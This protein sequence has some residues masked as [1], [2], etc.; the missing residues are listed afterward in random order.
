MTQHCPAC[1]RPNREGARFC[2]GCGVQLSATPAEPSA[3]GLVSHDGAFVGRDAELARLARCLASATGGR[4]QVAVVAGEP[5]IGKTR[6][7]QRCAAEAAARGMHVFWGRCKEEPGAPPYWPWLQALET[8]ASEADDD[9]L[10]SAL[11]RGAGHV[12][13]LAESIGTRFADLP[14]VVRASDPDRARFQTFDAFTSFWKRVAGP[15]GL[16]LVLDNLH[17]ADTASLR[18]LEFLAAAIEGDRILVLG[19]YRDIEL[20]RQHPM[21]N[22]LGELTRH[23]WATRLRLGGLTL[24]E[25]MQLVRAVTGREPPVDLMRVVFGQTEGNP[26]F[27]QEMARYLAHEGAIGGERSAGGVVVRRIP[28]GIREMIGTRLNRLSRACNEVLACAAVIGRAFRLDLLQR[29]DGV[30]GPEDCHAALE[31]A[32]A[33]RIVDLDPRSG[34]YEFTHALIRET[35]YD[36]LPAVRRARLHQQVGAILAASPTASEMATLAAVAHHYCTALPGGDSVTALE[37]AR[38]AADRAGAM[39]AYEEA[40]RLN[41]MA[42]QAADVAGTIDPVVRADLFVALGTALTYSGEYVDAREAFAEGAALARNLPTREAAMVLARAAIEYETASWRP[43]HQGDAAVRL[44]AQALERFAREESVEHV[45]VL[46]AQARALALTGA[47]DLAEAASERS[48]AM[49]RRLG[50]QHALETALRMGMAVDYASGDWAHTARLGAEAIRIADA[51]G[52]TDHAMEAATAYLASLMGSGEF[53]ARITEFHAFCE[54][55][56]AIRQPFYMY[57]ALTAQCCHALL[58]GR[59]AEAD[60]RAGEALDLGQR[61]PG[62]DA[63]GVYGLQMFNIRREQGRLGEVAPIIR[64]LA[65]SGQAGHAWRPGLALIYAEL[66]MRDEARREFDPL[67]ANDFAALP[68]DALRLT[69]LG[70]L[71]EVCC[72][73]RD[74]SR[75]AALYAA[76][77]PRAGTNLVSGANLVCVGA[78]DRILGSLAAVAGDTSAADAHFVAAAGANRAQGAMPWLGHTLLAH[79]TMLRGL[80]NDASRTRGEALI[81]EARR[82]ALSLDLPRLRDLAERIASSERSTSVIA[83]AAVLPA[84]LSAREAEV[85]RLV[86]IGRSNKEIARALDLSENTVANHVRSIL[87]KTGTANRTEAAGFARQAGL[88]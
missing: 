56:R 41:R 2:D 39:F 63:L 76:L 80:A 26:L 44:L 29:L 67:C 14:R 21:S 5:G 57:Y 77:L 61:Q 40:A 27:L 68:R 73:L 85:L 1:R 13:D 34:Q 53:N 87:A 54:R 74:A 64:Q 60:R 7:A 50:D 15:R 4:G 28:E 58:A 11:G 25:T 88:A 52:E 31:E 36:E 19:T 81:A 83:P 9:A 71:A 75:A 30:G 65:S 8:F 62:F 10:R 48:I 18:F 23:P 37:Y 22:T 43:G 46:A 79:G 32:E 55:A 6:L 49:A 66:D 35:L 42:L 33:A 47:S 12:A 70:Y 69:S 72:Y 20:T 51:I 38:R 45:R 84:G 16:L 82:I 3:A 59:L 17:A 86:T 24:P 78:I